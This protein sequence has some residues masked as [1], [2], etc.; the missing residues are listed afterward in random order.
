MPQYIKSAVLI[1]RDGKFLLVKENAAHVRGLWN[2]PQGKVEKGETTEK[3]AIRE[4]KEETGLDIK[5]EK[6]LG[7]LINTFADTKKLHVYTASIL[8][9]EIDFPTNE[10]MDVQ[11]FT[12]EQIEEM[13]DQLVGVWIHTT[14]S[15]NK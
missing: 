9:G 11:F 1:K 15:Q 3:A 4:A 10:I 13:R 5:L 7:V 14:I 2:W 8:G 6:P 12:F